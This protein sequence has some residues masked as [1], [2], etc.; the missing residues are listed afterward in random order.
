MISEV[1]RLN[2]K[3]NQTCTQSHTHTNNGLQCFFDASMSLSAYLSGW[4]N[5]T[6]I[7]QFGYC[8]KIIP[9]SLDNIECPCF[10]C[11]IFGWGFFLLC[12]CLETAFI[13]STNYYCPKA[14]SKL[15][16]I[17]FSRLF[18]QVVLSVPFVWLNWQAWRDFKYLGISSDSKSFGRF[19]N[20]LNERYKFND[21]LAN[22]RSFGFVTFVSIRFQNPN[23]SNAANCLT[24]KLC[25][26]SG[27]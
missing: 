15:S 2:T 8:S 25:T 22:A 1:N 13:A 23:F 6:Y 4:Q 27:M 19:W 17:F 10:S 20:I 21:V 5:T 16:S 3:P 18:I 7:L 24:Q 11:S 12:S 26:S 9:I 14:K